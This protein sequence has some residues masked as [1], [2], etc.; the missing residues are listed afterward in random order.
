MAR[1]IIVPHSIGWSKTALGVRKAAEK[2]H[3]EN[4]KKAFK[5][6]RKKAWDLV[7]SAKEELRSEFTNPWN[8]LPP[9]ALLRLGVIKPIRGIGA[10]IGFLVTTPID[11]VNSRRKSLGMKKA[12]TKMVA[13]SLLGEMQRD[14]ALMKKINGLVNDEELNWLYVNKAGQIVLS[15]NANYPKS[16][17][18]NDFIM[19]DNPRVDMGRLIKTASQTFVDAELAPYRTMVGLRGDTITISNM[20][21]HKPEE[22]IR[23]HDLVGVT[24]VTSGTPGKNTLTFLLKDGTTRSLIV[25]QGEAKKIYDRMN[26]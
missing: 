11:L 10:V 21:T 14:P 18:G 4:R 13:Y 26:K 22:T 3:K 25:E 9:V 1:Q 8:L 16:K 19:P 2:K 12:S 7:I 6:T 23:K 5:N 15:D 17:L 20:A 24:M